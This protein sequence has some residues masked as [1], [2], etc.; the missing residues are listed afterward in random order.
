MKTVQITLEEPLLREVDRAVKRLKTSR[1]AFVREAL[2]AALAR[3]REAELERSHRQG[4][5]RRPAAPGEFGDW[6][7]EQVW[8]E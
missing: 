5:Q 3:L 7:D 2:R 6:E 1:S 4:Y 8:V